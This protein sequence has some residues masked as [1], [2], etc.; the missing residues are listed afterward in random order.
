MEPTSI[1]YQVMIDD[2]VALNDQLV[3][4]QAAF[5]RLSKWPRFWM[6]AM[7]VLFGLYV[8]AA[9]RAENVFW[10]VVASLVAV[11]FAIAGARLPQRMRSASNTAVRKMYEQGDN[12]ASTGWHRLEL[13]QDSIVEESEI[14]QISIRYRGIQRPE[15]TLEHLFIYYGSLQAFVIPKQRIQSGDLEEFKTALQARLDKR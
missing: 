10:T 12:P 8:L 2:M 11:Y 1:E 5:R 13:R 4:G 3:Q 15:E 9:V 7:S 14:G 6:W